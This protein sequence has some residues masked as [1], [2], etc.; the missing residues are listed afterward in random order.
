MYWKHSLALHHYLL[1]IFENNRFTCLFINRP[2]CDVW[3][4]EN[5]D[6][7]P[8]H[9]SLACSPKTPQ[10]RHQNTPRSSGRQVG[11]WCSVCSVWFINVF[12]YVAWKCLFKNETS[13]FQPTQTTK[14]FFCIVTALYRRRRKGRYGMRS[15]KRHSTLSQT[16]FVGWPSKGK[17]HREWPIRQLRILKPRAVVNYFHHFQVSKHKY[18]Q[19]K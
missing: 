17:R 1:S 13:F 3:A 4:I 12:I 2:W 7:P 18:K 6:H 11:G 10:T 5:V 19:Q 9:P 15:R 14:R 16:R 8:T